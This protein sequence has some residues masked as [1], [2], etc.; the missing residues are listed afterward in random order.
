[1]ILAGLAPNRP[2]G[3]HI[4][5]RQQPRTLPG[6]RHRCRFITLILKKAPIIKT[7]PMF[8]SLGLS[9]HLQL[10]HR[11]GQPHGFQSQTHCYDEFSAEAPCCTQAAGEEESYPFFAELQNNQLFR[12][13]RPASLVAAPHT[14]FVNPMRLSIKVAVLPSLPRR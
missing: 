8:G 2:V 5:A 14:L 10:L 13:H 1:V 12:F 6:V 3:L 11:C 7:V 9:V 4:A